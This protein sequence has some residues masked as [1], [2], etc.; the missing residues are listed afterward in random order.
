[1]KRNNLVK[2]VA[3]VLVLGVAVLL[4]TGAFAI[5]KGSFHVAETVQ[6]SGQAIPAGEYQLRWEG[7]GSNVEV[8][9]MKGRKEIAK[10]TAKVYELDRPADHDST[11]LDK[12]SGKVTLSEV[13]FAG[14]K[15]ALALGSSDRASMSG[16]SSK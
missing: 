1:M 3:K 5:N 13:R 4:A 11:I 8:S 9:V 7:T 2:S 14:K 16:D 12:S 15:T 6:L 10:T